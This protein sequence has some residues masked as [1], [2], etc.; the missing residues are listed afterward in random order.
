MCLVSV[1]I[2]ICMCQALHKF[3]LIPFDFVNVCMYDIICL[4]FC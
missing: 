4:L 2:I 3:L 1:A